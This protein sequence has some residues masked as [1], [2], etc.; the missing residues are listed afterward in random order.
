[1]LDK[2]IVVFRKVRVFMHAQTCLGALTMLHELSH[3]ANGSMLNAHAKEEDQVW[4]LQLGHHFGLLD[5]IVL[6]H[7]AFFH[8]FDGYVYLGHPFSVADDPELSGTQLF[9]KRQLIGPYFPW[10]VWTTILLLLSVDILLTIGS[11]KW[12]SIE[13]SHLNHWN[14]RKYWF[15]GQKPLLKTLNLM[16]FLFEY[17]YILRKFNKKFGFVSMTQTK[18]KTKREGEGNALAV[19]QTYKWFWL[20]IRYCYSKQFRSKRN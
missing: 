9:Q 2:W 11:M 3:Y 5:E 7:R 19:R 20:A 6:W 15:C 14:H 4:V 10:L 18:T 13:W 17:N 16:L 1:M 8:Q 12:V